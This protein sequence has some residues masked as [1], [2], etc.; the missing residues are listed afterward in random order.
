MANSCFQPVDREGRYDAHSQTNEA[1]GWLFTRWFGRRLPTVTVILISGPKSE[2]VL[3]TLIGKAQ[4]L[5]VRY[6]VQQYWHHI[7]DST[8]RRITEVISRKHLD[9][10]ALIVFY[11]STDGLPF[12]YQVLDNKH[13]IV[14]CTND[15]ENAL[16]QLDENYK[17]KDKKV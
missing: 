10:D 16:Y 6:A 13:E 14:I 9:S 17:Q 3:N 5:G 12:N 15:V 7:P 2:A 1:T 4:I 8:L 11:I